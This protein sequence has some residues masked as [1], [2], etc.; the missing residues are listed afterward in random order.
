MRN[1]FADEVF[2]IAE[3]DNRLILLSGD[4][5]NK[6]FDRFKSLGSSRFFNCGVAE[7]NMMGVA[8]G[9][10]LCGLRPFVYTITPFTT[11]RCFEQIRVDVCYHNAPV[12]I[13]GTGSGL[14]YAD[15]GPTHHSLE[16]I[17]ILR[18][19][20]GMQVFAPCDT[21]EL[22]LCLREVMHLNAPAYIR[23]GKKG[24]PLIHENTPEF[25]IG[26]SIV[27]RPGKD[28]A[29]LCAGNM[30]AES[31][32]AA[33]ILTNKGISA[34]VVSFHTIKPLDINYLETLLERFKLMVSV[35]E[36]ARIGGFG[37]S[38]AEWRSIRN[39]PI[40]HL[41]IGADDVFMHEVGS[42]EYARR[43]FGLTA[44]SIVDKIEQSLGR[45]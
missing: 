40:E 1:A 10:A 11:T 23:I 38:I 8:A 31:I 6:L 26:R 32:K 20:P 3:A 17:G 30:M 35:E 27:I 24:E 15:L 37:G 21:T 36:H 22:R 9:M 33:D 2:K 13:V 18:I 44:E 29:I 12:V 42:Q 7:A 39:A 19:L 4:I 16:D 25:K 34:E 43:K 41:M 45:K 28:V 14:S 5:G